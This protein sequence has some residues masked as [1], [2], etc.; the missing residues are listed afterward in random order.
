M[1]DQGRSELA[2]TNTVVLNHGTASSPV[3]VK[4]TVLRKTI[5]RKGVRAARQRYD[6]SCLHNSALASSLS[7]FSDGWGVDTS[8]IGR[9]LRDA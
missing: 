1:C 7:R 9:L 2:R 4:T 3:I 8:G 6:I 5:P